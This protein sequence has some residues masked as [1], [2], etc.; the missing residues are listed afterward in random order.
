MET[1]TAK[2]EAADFLAAILAE[3]PQPVGRIEEEARAAGVLGGEQD[4]GQSKPFRLARSALGIKPRQA[5]GERA[6]GWVWEQRSTA[7]RDQ[8]ENL[9]K[10]EYDPLRRRDGLSH[11]R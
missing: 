10:R 6:P 1:R 4:I 5:K 8:A 3:G 11:C 2:E 9:H 7:R